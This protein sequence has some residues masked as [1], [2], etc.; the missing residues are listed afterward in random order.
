MGVPKKWVVF[1]MENPFNMDDLGVITPRDFH[2]LQ[3]KAILSIYEIEGRS[4][5]RGEVTG[6]Q[7]WSC[8]S[9]ELLL[10]PILGVS[11]MIRPTLG[12]LIV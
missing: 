6:N 10:K 9:C 12:T 8:V 3:V 5:S 11:N 2:M 4:G 7:L 1:I